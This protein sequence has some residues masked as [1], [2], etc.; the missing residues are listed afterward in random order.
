MYHFGCEVHTPGGMQWSLVWTIGRIRLATRTYLVEMERF[1]RPVAV[2][3]HFTSL[4]DY[5]AV[6]VFYCLRIPPMSI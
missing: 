4:R 6:F 1:I 5:L 2:V 3:L